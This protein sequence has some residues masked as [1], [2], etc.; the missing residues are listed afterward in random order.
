MVSSTKGRTGG[1]TLSCDLAEMTLFDIYQAVGEPAL[2]AMGIRNESSECLIEKAVNKT[3]ADSLQQAESLLMERFETITLQ[4]LYDE[5][6]RDLA[7]A[8][9]VPAGP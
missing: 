3:L 2:F 7:A 5:F 9:K 4:M 8:R 6:S 1:W